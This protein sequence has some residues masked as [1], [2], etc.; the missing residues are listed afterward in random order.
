MIEQQAAGAETADGLEIMGDDDEGAARGDQLFDAVPGLELEGV[1]A[2]RPDLVEEDHLGIEM[3]GHRQSQA[4]LHARGIM[5]D[6]QIH[7]A[8][9]LGEG[10]DVVIF[11]ADLG[12][13]HAEDGAAQIDVLMPGKIFVKTGADF[14][15]HADAAAHRSGAYRRVGD[16]GEDLQ[17]RALAGA[18][19]AENADHLALFDVEADI[20]ERPEMGRRLF[21]LAAES[22]APPWRQGPTC[23]PRPAGGIACQVQRP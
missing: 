11:L 4:Q 6:G 22:G 8:V 2:D 19:M 15:Q 1:V 3:D 20:V 13:R 12:A 14:E 17:Q 21:L 23:R 10:D 16:A 9:H 5:A 18:I 7:E